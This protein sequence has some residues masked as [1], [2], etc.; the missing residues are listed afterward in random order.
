MN[1]VKQVVIA[2]FN[3]KGKVTA[4]EWSHD[5]QFFAVAIGTKFRVFEVPPMKKAVAPLVVYKKYGNMHSQDICGIAWSMDSRFH[6]TWSSDM[7]LKMMS[8]HKLEG[9]SPFTFGGNKK[10]IVKAFYSKDNK[11]IFSINA[12][13]LLNLWKFV[14]EISEGA[15]K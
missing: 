14:D 12:R 6:L 4:I 8:L 13:G 15:K 3:F 10:E 7:T 2:Y 9:F 1:F 11:R 5:S